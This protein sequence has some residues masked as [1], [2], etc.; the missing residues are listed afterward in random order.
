MLAKAQYNLLLQNQSNGKRMY[1][2]LANKIFQ[3]VLIIVSFIT[4]IST[5]IAQSMSGGVDPF[6]EAAKYGF[7]V[8]VLFIVLFLLYKDWKHEK[9]YSREEIK[10][11]NTVILDMSVENR[12]AVERATHAMERN[13][14]TN[15]AI[16]D[17]I[18]DMKKD[19]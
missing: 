9:E 7:A 5:N 15:E 11:L 18:R 12:K 16:L 4:Y 17:L 3:G 1:E 6:A 2:L 10:S 14:D 8:L 19:R 13:S